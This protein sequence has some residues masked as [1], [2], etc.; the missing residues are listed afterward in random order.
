MHN[1]GTFP[2]RSIIGRPFPRIRTLLAKYPTGCEHIAWASLVF[3]LDMGL[4][5]E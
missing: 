4:E 1:D 2:G 5:F 3:E